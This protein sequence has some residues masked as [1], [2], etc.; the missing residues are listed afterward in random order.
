MDYPED[1]QMAAV[2]DLPENLLTKKELMEQTQLAL[3]KLP[4]IYNIIIRMHFY[5]G[6]P[7]VEISEIL[8]I[9]INTI[10]SYVF[11][12]KKMIKEYLSIEKVD[13]FYKSEWVYGER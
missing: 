8:Q 13:Y 1:N 7:Y 2:D 4:D 11:R 9:P 10:K 6:L 5:D 3:K 12:A